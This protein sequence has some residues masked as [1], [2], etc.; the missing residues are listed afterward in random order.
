M[1]EYLIKPYEISV[2]KNELIQDGNE[3]RFVEKKLAIIGSNTMT[4]LNKVYDPVFN[5][6]MN[7]EKSLT[8]SLK[9]KY[10]DTY[11][12]EEVINP[13]VSLLTNESKVKLH[14]DDKW[15]E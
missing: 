11:T 15:Y 4:G 8:F 5:K 13:F 9:Y 3:Q 10:V 2:W 6:K 12:G 14:Y 1:G 7:G